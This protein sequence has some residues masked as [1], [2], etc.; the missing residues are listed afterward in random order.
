M[1]ASDPTAVTVVAHRGASHDFPEHSLVAFV[2]A[3][4]VGADALECD[5]R[6]SADGHLVCVHDSTVDRTSSGR[7]PVAGQTLAQLRSY[8]W[9]TPSGGPLTL[10]E[11]FELARDCGRRVELA[12]ETKHPSR[13]GGAVEQALTDLMDWF[14]WLPTESNADPGP[15]RVMSFSGRALTRIRH[16]SPRVPLVYLVEK[17]TPAATR[18]GLPGHAATLGISVDLLGASDWLGRIGARG[19]GLHVWTVDDVGR[20]DDCLA[21]GATAIITNRPAEIRRHLATLTG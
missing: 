16:R 2:R 12:V 7:G 17:P 14:G 11:L 6:L 9:G 4:D 3:I 18:A 15:V 10:R 5:V 8:D 1:S 13:F 20:I 19:H 21:A